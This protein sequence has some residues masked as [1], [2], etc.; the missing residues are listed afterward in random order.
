MGKTS[1]RVVE[2][3]KKKEQIISKLKELYLE[4]CVGN[5]KESMIE[6]AFETEHDHLKSIWRDHGNWKH[7]W[8]K[9]G[10]TVC[11]HCSP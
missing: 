4:V 2:T 3:R 8:L 1:I 10:R 5:V 11:Y 7:R 6:K 9:L